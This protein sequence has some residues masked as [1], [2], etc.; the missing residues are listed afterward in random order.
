MYKLF[1]V[2]G[3][4]FIFHAL[5]AV[6]LDSSQIA[7]II[8]FRIE[9]DPPGE[10]LKIR[11][12]TLL[13]TDDV[14]NFYTDRYFEE[15]WSVEGILSELAYALRFEIKQSQ[16][17]GLNPRDYN[18]EAIDGFFSKFETN[19]AM[20][21]SNDPG[22]LADLDMLLSDAFF[23][24]ASHLEIGK[25]DPSLID[26]EWEIQRKEQLVYYPDLL[27]EAIASGQIR[28]TLETLYPK[29]PVYKR[30][31]EVLRALVEEEKEDSLN[32]KKVKVSKAL[33]VGDTNNDIPILRERL[34]YWGLLD[35]Y[36]VKEPKL[37]DSVM[38]AGIK[39]FQGYHGMVIDGV[40]GKVTAAALNDSPQAKIDKARVNLERLRWLPDT[41]ENAEFILV[42]IANFQ[43]DY[44]KNLDTLLTER[45]I[46]GRKYH[47]TPIFMEEMSYIVFS[48]YWNI[49]YSITRGEIIPSARKNPNYINSKNMEV[50]TPAGQVVDPNS[51]DW[52][53]KS[54][55]YLVRQKPGPG[56]SLGLVKF[57]F[58]NKHNV[59][60]HD[61]NARSLFAND[62]RSRSH[63]C[64][65]IQNPADFAKMLLRDEPE[66]T[67][68]RINEAM[69]QTHEQVVKLK[70]PIP[71]VLVYLTFWA[72]SKGE[73][74]FRD[75]I[76]ERDQAVLMALNEKS[77]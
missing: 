50:V 5:D 68:E 32:W 67:M 11:N 48:P 56:N 76:Y 39:D 53:S 26:E 19:M 73:A 66:W 69:S 31:R 3:F 4:F 77:S 15:V 7:E 40:I 46:V 37:Y 9:T 17:D 34:Q 47:E 36:E 6:P 22:D 23:H 20:G 59:Y 1:L 10:K 51:I 64:I 71:V 62:D 41:V 57:M 18:L 55:P 61:T 21:K 30:G 52:H 24:L 70:K 16:F 28:Q 29:F 45:V 60:I 72:D 75:D 49:P 33:K 74:H 13:T 58:P 43:L 27:D 35:Q 38:M 8:R 42:N 63:G 44:F 2:V 14:I 12:T 65:R 25:V 54:F